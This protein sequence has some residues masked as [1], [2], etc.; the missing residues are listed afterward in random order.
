MSKS[1]KHFFYYDRFKLNRNK[2]FTALKVLTQLGGTN[3]FEINQGSH[4]NKK[5]TYL[6]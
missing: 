2:G 3:D 1:E 6:M 5:D 4:E